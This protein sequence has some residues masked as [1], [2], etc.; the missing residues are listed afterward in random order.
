WQGVPSI[1]C[2][3]FSTHSPPILNAS[4]RRTRARGSNSVTHAPR[5]PRA[6]ARFSTSARKK[7]SPISLAV[8]SSTMRRAACAERA[9]PWSEDDNMVASCHARRFRGRARATGVPRSF[10]GTTGLLLLAVVLAHLLP[11]ALVV[12]LAH[13]G[14][15]LRALPGHRGSG[16]GGLP[17]HRA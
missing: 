8:P 10:S 17:H 9:G 5:V 11:G 16:L 6:R 13:H 1:G 7:P 14:D 12:H 15:L 2:S 4:A 3:K